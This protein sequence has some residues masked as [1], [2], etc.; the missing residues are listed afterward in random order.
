VERVNDKSALIGSRRDSDVAVSALK[1]LRK[2]I[3]V[4]RRA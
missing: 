1:N 3:W 2:N 4:R